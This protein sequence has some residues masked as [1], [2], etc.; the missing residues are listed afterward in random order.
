MA[1]SGAARSQKSIL[2]KAPATGT[3]VRHTRLRG[4]MH[5]LL[6]YPEFPDS[7]F[8]SYRHVMRMVGAKAPFPPLGL[9][10]FAALMPPH[11]SFDLLDL[12]VERPSDDELRET[13]RLR[14]RGVRERDVRAEAIA[15]RPA[16]RAGPRPRHAVGARRAVSRRAI[17]TTSCTRRRSPTRSSIA[18][19]TAWCGARVANG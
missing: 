13:H 11:W 1:A 3:A 17:A 6:L 7:S 5:G 10:T 4:S 15:R 14:R 2:R 8:W 9:I 19:S 12:N 18:A 16:L